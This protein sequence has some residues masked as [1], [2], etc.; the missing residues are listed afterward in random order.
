MR[1][2]YRFPGRTGATR[3]R[4]PPCPPLAAVTASQSFPKCSGRTDLGR[5]VGSA[6]VLHLADL[7]PPRRAVRAGGD[8][9]RL[10]GYFDLG[11]QS[12]PP[13]PPPLL[14]RHR[15]ATKLWS[16]SREA[17]TSPDAGLALPL[18]VT[19]PRSAALQVGAAGQSRP[20]GPEDALRGSAF[21]PKPR[22][23]SPPGC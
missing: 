11:P 14:C 1:G 23:V 16:G 2:R 3:P 19:R 22:P 10:G 12:V 8:C 5:A 15:R 13:G 18:G 9:L 7:L 20:G 21:A 17:R 6:V 4:D